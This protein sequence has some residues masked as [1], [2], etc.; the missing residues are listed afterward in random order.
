LATF[1]AERWA[2]SWRH[3]GGAVIWSG[4]VR[5]GADGLVAVQLARFDIDLDELRVGVPLRRLAVAQQPVQPGPNEH[6][7]IGATQR[8]RAGGCHRLW[9]AVGQQALGH[10]HRQ[11]GQ[12]GGFDERL[13]LVVGLRVC[14]SLAQH[15]QRSLGVGEQLDR[16]V[17]C[18]GRRELARR[19]V[20]DPPQ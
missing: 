18:L 9:V 8:Q 14:C 7:D 1:W 11:I 19:E 6:H 12:P 20:N 17:H 16:A 2:N 15:H 4:W 5:S 3:C 13:Y 10:R